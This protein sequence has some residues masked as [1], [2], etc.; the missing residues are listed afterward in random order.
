MEEVGR[1]NIFIFGLSTEEVSA[2]RPVYNPL[3]YYQRDPLL[4]R[5]TDLI[6]EGFFSP[7]EPEIFRPL[8]DMLLN[9][10]RYFVLADFEAYHNCQ[11]EVDTLYRDQEEW[12]KKAI[13]NVAR[14]GKFSSD[15]TIMEYNRDI[16]HAEPWPVLKE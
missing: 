2:M 15:R 7:E 6:R 9:D 3:E 14:M 11:R 13:L 1:E 4:T 10:D 12:T 16:W 8:I 5:A